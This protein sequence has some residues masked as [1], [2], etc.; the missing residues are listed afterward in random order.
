MHA[1]KPMLPAVILHTQG[2]RL[3]GFL[4]HELAASRFQLA[5]PCD[6]DAVAPHDFD[7][8]IVERDHIDPR[9]V[10]DDVRSYFPE[11]RIISIVTIGA[12]MIVQA[13]ATVPRAADL[14]RLRVLAAGVRRAATRAGPNTVRA[15]GA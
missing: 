3:T 13:F 4:A 10:I 15:R 11:A 2:C 14:E 9:G 7:V 12:V 6:P 1:Y 8:M 5:I